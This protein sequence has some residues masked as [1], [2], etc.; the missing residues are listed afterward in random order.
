LSNINERWESTRR[1]ADD[2]ELVRRVLDG[3]TGAYATLVEKYQSRI[4]TLVGRMVSRRDMIEDLSQEVFIKAYRKL[5]TFRFESSFYTWLYAVALNTVRNWYRRQDPPSTSIDETGELE[6]VES[7]GGHESPED[8]AGR[9][10]RAEI[11]RRALEGLPP[12]QKEALVL[13]DLEGLSYQEIADVQGVPV[14]TVRSRIFRARA[15]L[16]DRLPEE[17]RP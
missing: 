6:A 9:S 10:Q 15:A 16:R 12:E 14:G 3:D 17:M 13:S 2:E 7:S 11:V 5:G 8:A 1:A 4:F